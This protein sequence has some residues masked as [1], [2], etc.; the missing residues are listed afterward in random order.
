MGKYN[1]V[2]NGTQNKMTFVRNKRGKKNPFARE[3]I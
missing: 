1:F 2:L 3:H